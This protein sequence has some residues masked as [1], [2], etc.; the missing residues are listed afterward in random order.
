MQYFC[1]I[2]AVFKV[3]FT[4]I[5]TKKLIDWVYLCVCENIFCQHF[6]SCI[7]SLQHWSCIITMSLIMDMLFVNIV[8]VHTFGRAIL[9][10]LLHLHCLEFTLQSLEIEQHYWM[11]KWMND[12]CILRN[13]IR[14]QLK[15]LFL[16]HGWGHI[17]GQSSKFKSWPGN[18]LMPTSVLENTPAKLHPPQKCS[19]QFNNVCYLLMLAP[20]VPPWY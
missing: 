10:S 6:I 13:T 16:S 7:E 4:V 1:S 5:A 14:A 3:K 12:E 17:F 20:C 2:F 9:S 18:I 15:Q 11:S 19:V 8:H